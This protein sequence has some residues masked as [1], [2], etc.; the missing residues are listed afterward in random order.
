M[1]SVRAINFVRCRASSRIDN[2]FRLEMAFS[3]SDILIL[4]E[5]S[6]GT[7]L[8]NLENASREV[9]ILLQTCPISFRVVQ[10]QSFIPFL[11]SNTKLDW[12]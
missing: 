7:I 1:R 9:F 10:T 11:G 6:V 5:G 3:G 8:V 2:V 12:F 4:V